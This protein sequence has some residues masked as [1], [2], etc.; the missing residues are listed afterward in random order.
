[1]KK[2]FGNAMVSEGLL[3][4]R[5]RP[6]GL[7]AVFAARS[8]P[9]PR[10][11]SSAKRVGPRF[12]CFQAIARSRRRVHWSRSR[13]YDGVS[14]K[15]KQLRHPVRYESGKSLPARGNRLEPWAPKA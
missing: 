15:P 1:V 11:R 5:Q 3:L 13:N 12:H 2:A 7:P 8:R 10:R 14:Q 6:C 4:S 9:T